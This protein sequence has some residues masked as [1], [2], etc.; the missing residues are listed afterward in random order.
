MNADK[1]GRIIKRVK[2]GTA[3]QEER[4]LL[5]SRWEKA[6]GDQD[7]LR[8]FSP[9]DREELRAEMYQAISEQIGFT[10]PRRRNSVALLY[11]VVFCRIR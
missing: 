8:D 4:E 6:L 3:T 1:L 2:E 5:E 9:S 7:G 11:K 10:V